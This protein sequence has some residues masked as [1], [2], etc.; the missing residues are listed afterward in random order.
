M[1]CFVNHQ[2]V[3]SLIEEMKSNDYLVCGVRDGGIIK[4]AQ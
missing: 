1:Y 2:K 4:Q 3:F